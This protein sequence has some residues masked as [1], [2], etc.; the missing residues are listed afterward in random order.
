MN[1][2]LPFIQDLNILNIM[3]AG[4]RKKILTEIAK[5]QDRMD[6][7]PLDKP[8]STRVLSIECEPS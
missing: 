8:V 2:L 4:H 7:L 1:S 5:D 3:K 6:G